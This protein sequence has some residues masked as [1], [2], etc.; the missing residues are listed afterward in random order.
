MWYNMWDEIKNFRKRHP[1]NQL[2]AFD[3]KRLKKP[4]RYADGNNLYLFIDSNGS[5]RWVLR[6]TVGKRRRDM[7]LGS[8]KLVAL[9]KAR[10]LAILYKSQARSG[11]DPFIERKKEL[12]AFVTFRS[13][14][15][16]V[17]RIVEPGLKNKRFAKSWLSSI[18]QH[19]YPHIGQL[20]VSQIRPAH[21]LS[22]LTP[23]W[24]TKSETARKI[25]QRLTLIMKWSRAQGYYDGYDPVEIAE[26]AL[27]KIKR[28]KEHFK[29][30]DFNELP[31]LI[32][33]IKKSELSIV[34]KYAMEFII[35]TAGRT[36]EV[37]N[38]VW[39]EINL[40]K[41]IW[42]IPAIRMKNNKE[43]VVPLTIRMIEILK[44]LKKHNKNSSY[45]FEIS[46]NKPISNNTMRI[47]LKK[48]LKIDATIHGMRS[49]FKDWASEKTN[50][51]NEVSE[52][53]LAHSI[54]NKVEASYRRG[55][56]LEKRRALMNQWE[57]FLYKRDIKIFTIKTKKR[58]N[59]FLSNI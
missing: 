29:A 23:I 51:N 44:E 31:D 17:Y 32:K 16:S 13:C 45:I 52:M 37:I 38:A 54:T 25:K 7:G 47:A 56:L 14:A 39:H 33:K 27:P 35:L 8:A 19:V 59:A 53:A 43:H 18:E 55:N 58:S 50:F 11:L 26:Q 28:I 21:I 41:E 1:I 6:L 12:G 57:H 42:T 4:G 22:V 5:K 24:N 46:N 36:T 49:S 15:E 34:T 20:P 10:E 9:K 40:E 2:N 48:R 30:V 3:I